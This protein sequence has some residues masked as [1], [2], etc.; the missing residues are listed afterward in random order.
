MKRRKRPM[1]TTQLH[2]FVEVIRVRNNWLNLQLTARAKNC[3]DLWPVPTFPVGS[4][5]IH[6]TETSTWDE[7]HQW[8][9]LG[10]GESMIRLAEIFWF[11]ENLLSISLMHKHR[12]RNDRTYCDSNILFPLC[13]FNLLFYLLVKWASCLIDRLVIG[14]RGHSIL[15]NLF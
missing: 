13:V 8:T 11:E 7:D 1:A 2:R 10:E 5:K 3:C 12:L 9:L 15:F 4:F 6:F 14:L